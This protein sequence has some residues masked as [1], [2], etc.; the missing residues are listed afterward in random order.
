[1]NIKK[2]FTIALISGT[3]FTSCNNDPKK[4]KDNLEEQKSTIDIK[5]LVGS[6]EDQSESAL[7]FSL[8]SDGTAQSDNMETLVYKQWNVKNNQLYLVAES[9]GNRTSSIDTMV[10]DIQQLDENQMV[11][12]RDAL[13]FPIK[14][15][16]KPSH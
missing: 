3:L 13:I 11:L 14:R 2:I 16:T 9:I 8:L 7:N 12:K 6:W 10:Y 4:S 15:Q 1:M 5:L